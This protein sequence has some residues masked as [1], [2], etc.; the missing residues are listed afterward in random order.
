MGNSTFLEDWAYYEANRDRLSKDY[1]GKFVA[2]VDG[3]VVDSDYE[4]GTLS[5]RIYRTYGYR[6][7][8]MTRA[9]REP[10]VVNVRSPRAFERCGV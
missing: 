4:F 10:P 9:E 1:D 7:I 2:I 3:T 6:A 5:Q 8:V